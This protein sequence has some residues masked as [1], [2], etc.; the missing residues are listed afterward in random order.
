MFSIKEFIELCIIFLNK[1]KCGTD[2]ISELNFVPVVA[3]LCLRTI[4]HT[5]FCLITV[6][7]IGAEIA[8]SK[9]CCG[10]IDFSFLFYPKTCVVKPIIT[11]CID[12]RHAFTCSSAVC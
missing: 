4:S 10:T 5:N 8:R 3:S 2:V 11:A 12:K 9:K 6:P 1:F 7:A